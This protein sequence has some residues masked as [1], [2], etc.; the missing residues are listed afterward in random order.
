[1]AEGCIGS[2]TAKEQGMEISRVECSGGY[3]WVYDQLGRRVHQVPCNS[4]LG[5]GPKGMVVDRGSMIAVVDIPSMNQ[6]LISRTQ[7]ESMKW[8]LHDTHFM[9][10]K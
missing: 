2:L 3:A 1:M 6:R 4:L 7:F 8:E 10:R 9:V 5:Y